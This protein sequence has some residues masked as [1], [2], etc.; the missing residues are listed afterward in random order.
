MDGEVRRVSAFRCSGGRIVTKSHDY[1][2]ADDDMSTYLGRAMPNRF[3]K[4]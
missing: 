3:T 4:E 1:S 2:S